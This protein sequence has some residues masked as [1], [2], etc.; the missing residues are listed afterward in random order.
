MVTYWTESAYYD[1]EGDFIFT[2]QKNKAHLFVYVRRMDGNEFIIGKKH[3]K[4]I[5]KS[6]NVISLGRV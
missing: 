4:Y 6:E 3:S 2:I 5:L 1:V